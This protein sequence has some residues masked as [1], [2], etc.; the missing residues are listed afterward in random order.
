ME[1]MVHM[2]I[3]MYIYLFYVHLVYLTT[4]C[5]FVELRVISF[6]FSVLGMLYK[7]KS[8]NPDFRATGGSKYVTEKVAFDT[9][10][11]DQDS[12]TGF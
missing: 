6:I 7:D 4:I 5:F 10:I 1:D 3:H 11:R 12:G 8:G 2:Y 9:K